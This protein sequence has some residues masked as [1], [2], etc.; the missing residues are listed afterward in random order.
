MMVPQHA[1]PCAQ[2]EQGTVGKSGL[3]R[4]CRSFLRGLFKTS[5]EVQDQ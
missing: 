2:A 3:Y 5:A 1:E 4:R